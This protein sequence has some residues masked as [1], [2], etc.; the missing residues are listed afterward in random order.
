[1]TR[2][3]G[4]PGSI[5]SWVRKFS[6]RRD[7]LPTPAFLG[8]SGGSEVKNPSAMWDTWLWP[9]GW[10]DL[11]EKRI[12]THSSIQVWRISWTEEPGR[13]QSMGS[14]RVRHD[15]VTFTSQCITSIKKG[16]NYTRTEFPESLDMLEF[17]KTEKSQ[18]PLQ[19]LSPMLWREP[20]LQQKTLL[21]A[22]KTW[23]SQVNKYMFLREK[24]Q[25]RPE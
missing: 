21:P 15:W 13:L 22:A 12:A 24:R 25:K 17:K 11:L 8:F 6:W 4:D 20:V 14:Q 7:R 2:N 9:L 10:E 16:Q 3:A 18:N 5:P 19:L 23:H 1:M